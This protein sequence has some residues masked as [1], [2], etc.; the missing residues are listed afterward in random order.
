MPCMGDPLPSL[1]TFQKPIQADHWKSTASFPCI[2]CRLLFSQLNTYQKASYFE[3]VRRIR[4]CILTIRGGGLAVA[5]SPFLSGNL[6]VVIVAAVRRV[7]DAGH[8]FLWVE[9][10]LPHP[11][12]R[13]ASLPQQLFVNIVDRL[14][15][16]QC[17]PRQALAS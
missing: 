16:Y 17:K 11:P 4:W 1:P 7:Q 10:V 9:I 14:N 12:L 3:C 2:P 13:F 5:V 6:C 8:I 15:Q